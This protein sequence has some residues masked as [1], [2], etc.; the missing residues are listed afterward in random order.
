MEVT[1]C[2]VGRNV[3]ITIWDKNKYWLFEL[4]MFDTNNSHESNLN[5]EVDRYAIYYA[6]S[7]VKINFKITNRVF[8]FKFKCL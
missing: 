2:E 3:R 6:D 4:S 1:N 7:C 5:E 8:K